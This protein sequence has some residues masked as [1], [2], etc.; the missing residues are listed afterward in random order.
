MPSG[1]SDQAPSSRRFSAAN[2]FAMS[3]LTIRRAI[4]YWTLGIFHPIRSCWGDP[5]SLRDRLELVG[6]VED[7]VVVLLAQA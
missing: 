6:D 3:R 1:A 7:A 2:W 5:R 4:G